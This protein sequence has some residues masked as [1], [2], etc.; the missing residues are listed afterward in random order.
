MNHPT[1]GFHIVKKPFV[2]RRFDN[3]FLLREFGD[4]IEGSRNARFFYQRTSGDSLGVLIGQN[5]TQV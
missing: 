1:T 5:F 3:V 2:M 4:G